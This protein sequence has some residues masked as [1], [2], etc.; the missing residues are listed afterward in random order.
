M[1]GQRISWGSGRARDAG[2]P[3]KGA[4]VCGEGE[5]W[6]GSYLTGCL[7][8]RRRRLGCRGGSRGGGDAGVARGPSGGPAQG[9]EATRSLDWKDASAT[10]RRV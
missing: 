2:V 4:G 10:V 3:G 8:L 9:L 6:K 1:W 5:S 7:T